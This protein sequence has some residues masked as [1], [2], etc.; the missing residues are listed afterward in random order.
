VEDTSIAMNGVISRG[1][2]SGAGM[3]Y[4]LVALLLGA[5]ASV[6]FFHVLASDHAP[7]S[8]ACV[9]PEGKAD[10]IRNMLLD[11]LKSH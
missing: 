3:K 7:D 8:V 4:L 5:I 10:A 11:H 2:P 6:E 1:K 9:A